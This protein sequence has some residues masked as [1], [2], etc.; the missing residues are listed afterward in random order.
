MKL[1]VPLLLTIKFNLS[2]VI[3]FSP[4]EKPTVQIAKQ[5]IN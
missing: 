5:M 4:V 1:T 2:Y 3:A